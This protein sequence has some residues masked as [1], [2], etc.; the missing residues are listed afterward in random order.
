MLS[1]VLGQALVPVAGGVVLGLG[2]SVA[3][4]RLVES[5]LFGVT[6]YDLST[7]V[8]TVGMLGLVTLGAAYLPAR[9]ALA[10]QP[11]DA[12]RAD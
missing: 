7:F 3:S 6:P 1:L 10:I 4:A 12:L 11:I 5:L 9:R 2:G 8:A